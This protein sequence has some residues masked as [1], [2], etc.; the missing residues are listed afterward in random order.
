MKTF[1]QL[2]DT[3]IRL[4]SIE[5]YMPVQIKCGK[6]DG[7]FLGLFRNR[8]QTEYGIE[9]RTMSGAT[10][11]TGYPTREERDKALADMDKNVP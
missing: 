4:S 11:Y 10:F 6:W 5:A 7:T 2:D 1:G 3:R 9:T 8:D